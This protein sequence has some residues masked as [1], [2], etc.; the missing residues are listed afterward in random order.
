VFAVRTLST[1]LT[2]ALLGG[3]LAVGPI[4]QV[5]AAPAHAATSPSNQYVTSVSG[6]VTG[7]DGVPLPGTVVHVYHRSGSYV[8]FATTDAQGRYTVT[9]LSANS[10]KLLFEP[11]DADAYVR[12]WWKDKSWSESATL[13]NVAQ[14]EKVTGVD[15]V[16]DQGS[17]VSGRVTGD[18]TGA[19]LLDARVHLNGVDEQSGHVQKQVNTDADGNYA[20]HGLARGQY[21]LEV[22]PTGGNY[23]REWWQDQPTERTATSF[24]V[25]VAATVSGMDV[26]LPQG[27]SISGTIAAD[28][29]PSVGLANVGVW[30]YNGDQDYV[31]SALT[32]ATGNYTVV[33]LIPDTYRLL[34]RPFD[35][36]GNY[37]DRF[38]PEW[39]DD[40]AS[41]EAAELIELGTAETVTGIN[42]LIGTSA[43]ITGTVTSEGGPAMERV[44]VTAHTK[45]GSSP[46]YAVTD[47][48]G[49]YTLAG[50]RPGAYTLQFEDY[51]WSGFASEWWN[52]QAAEASAEYFSVPAGGTVTRDA[53]LAKG[54]AITGTAL[55]EGGGEQWSFE[56]NAYANGKLVKTGYT[57][58]QGAIHLDNLPA[59][60]YTLEFTGGQGLPVWWKDQPGAESATPIT[61]ASGETV[62]NINLE[63]PRAATISGTVTDDGSPGDGLAYVEVYAYSTSDPS[64]VVAN[65]RTDSRGEYTIPGLR[66]GS[67]NL[68]FV[69]EWRNHASEWWNDQ[70][71]QK[72]STPITVAS[73]QAVTGTN[74]VLAA[75]AAI[76]GSVKSDS[77]A[78]LRNVR[79]KAVALDEGSASDSLYGVTDYEGNYT[80]TGLSAGKYSLQFV[81]AA[82]Q[83]YVG[84][85]W[86]DKTR[87]ADATYFTVA[88][89]Q[90]VTGKDAVLTAGASLSGSVLGELPAGVTTDDVS[91]EAFSKNGDSAGR[92]TADLAGRFVLRGLRAGTYT[93][94]FSVVGTQLLEWW[95]DQPAQDTAV[96]VTLTAGQKQTGVNVDFASNALTAAP[97]PTITGTAQAGKTLTASAGT[98]K[99]APVALTYQWF[100]ATV[101]IPG[102]TAAT[103]LVTGDDAGA[104]ITVAVTGIKTGF[105]T[106]SKTSA[107]VTVDRRLTDTPAPTITGTT[108]VG[109]K[110]TAAAGTWG[111]A[112]VALSYQWLRGTTVIPGATKSTYTLTTADAGKA[113]TV[114]VIGKKAGHT[115]VTTTSSATPAI[116]KPL[117]ATPTPSI[118]GTVKVGQTLTAKAGTWSPATVT[119]KYQWLRAGT[120]IAGATASTYKPVAADAGARLSVSVTGSRTG[121]ATVSK[122]SVTTAVVS[123]GV[124]TA[125]PAPTITG[126]TTVGHTL[127]ATTAAWAPATV[128]L[129]YQWLRAGTAIA[130]ATAST[131]KLVAAD[132]G[133]TITVKVSGTKSGFTTV[134]KTSAATAAIANVLTATPTPAI[135]G[136]VKVGQTLAAKPGSWSPAPVTLT[137]KWL[138]A[139]KAIA[140]ATTSTYKLVTADA[141]ATLTVTVTGSK[142]GYVTVAKTS[143]A[144]ASVT[145]AVLTA[146]PVPSISGTTTVG[147][148]LTAKTGSWAPA[149]VTLS[150]Q[151]LRSGTAISAATASTYTLAAADAGKTITLKVSGTKPGFTT[152]AKTSAATAAIARPLTNTPTPSISGTA[153]VGQKLTA[154]PGVWTPAPVSL[155][156]QWL[157]G[158]TAIDGATRGT[159]T[160]VAADV[161]QTLTVKVTGSKTGYVAVAKASAA[162]V[163]VVK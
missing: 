140:G 158:S 32:D 63:I 16:L 156:Y 64:V 25:G 154:K 150:Y 163:K 5:G 48:N 104:A 81:P 146:T 122:T 34:I 35:G 53:A 138:R 41:F 125:T 97:T 99:P 111:P 27:A 148:T 105:N 157:R 86:N 96:A 21:T 39:Y 147:Q 55:L 8:D 33:A 141:G 50:L 15:A 83:N 108:T 160:P 124:L 139:G 112:P 6:T 161:G 30:V 118:T 57:D 38:T 88:D 10:F 131:H 159:Y 137:Y 72:A 117:T 130:G 89:Q 142:T 82:S 79:V 74:A 84:E 12:E 73:G 90:E 132:A 1:L 93:I 3:L 136:T 135:S 20:F 87:K 54:G 44:H 28:A 31:G 7:A 145:G 37:D 100:R 66:A 126:T 4:A 107:S 144:T 23:L 76:S 101:A 70:P 71:T 91:V 113:I 36:D 11:A 133:K 152:V 13:L 45:N 59:G 119:L 116:T 65:T 123:G 9:G 75:A 49:N 80:I 69:A 43:T 42:A 29:A 85:Y 110:L 143:V 128:A 78:I 151:W 47:A 60:T 26:S 129:K 121:Y 24:P 62:G 46:A 102:A 58:S 14:Y 2:S 51:S 92:T 18:G 52:N 127:T 77:G 106:T 98:W 149:T 56:V 22:V 109:Q 162:T 103:Y 17:T 40:Q 153:K 120:A 115:A 67:Y 94:K 61:I 68:K 155:K 114:T 19:A 95:N 134:A